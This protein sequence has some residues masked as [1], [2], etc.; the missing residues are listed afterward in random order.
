MNF[1]KTLI[2]SFIDSFKILWGK[3]LIELLYLAYASFGQIYYSS[4]ILLVYLFAFVALL[5]TKTTSITFLIL[6]WFLNFDCLAFLRPSVDF[7]NYKYFFSY[8]LVAIKFLSIILLVF[9]LPYAILHFQ[10]LS[11][12]S[13]A[14][15][16]FLAL[17]TL[18]TPSYF[19]GLKMVSAFFLSSACL[20]I[21]IGFKSLIYHFLLMGYLNFEMFLNWF[22][23][24]FM[25][26]KQL[27]T[28]FGLAGFLISPA[29]VFIILGVLDSQKTIGSQLQGLVRGLKLF[30]IN[31]PIAF[32]WFKLFQFL[33]VHIYKFFA[34]NDL[35]TYLLA[36]AFVFFYYFYLSFLTNLYVKKVHEQF[37]IY[38]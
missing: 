16:F 19:S 32:I 9:Y 20:A 38:F 3:E 29:L 2:S 17:F 21:L 26:D 27:V 8:L 25:F 35:S 22:L 18:F 1:L 31:Y 30:L 23:Y 15:T 24:I 28:I 4:K 13:F 6:F 10:S 36:V 14:I 34:L 12:T 33:V 7:K 37:L 5:F 11:I